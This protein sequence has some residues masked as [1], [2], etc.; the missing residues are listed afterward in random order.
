[1][2]PNMNVT[3]R[4]LLTTFIAF[5]L[6]ISGIAAYIQLGNKAFYDGPVLAHGNY[7][8]SP[9][10]NCPPYDVPVRG[11]I[12]DRNGVKL[13][14]SVQDKEFPC[15]YH[16]QYDPRVATSGLAPLLG[17]YSARYLSEGLEQ[18]YNDQLAGVNSGETASSVFDSLLHKPRYGQD[19]YLTIDINLQVQAAKN[20]SSAVNY[21]ASPGNG[22]CQDPGTSPAGS[23]IAEDPFSGQILAMVSFPSFDPN[24]IDTPGYFQQIQAQAN[25]PFLN[26]ATMGLYTPG[27]TFKTVTLLAALDAGKATLDT[28][29]TKDEAV[30]YQVPQGET[31]RW[32][33]FLAPNPYPRGLQF[34]ISLNQAYW[35]SDNVVFAREAVGMGGDTWLQY[36]RKFGIS[37]PGYDVPPVKFD[38][39]YKQSSAYNDAKDQ[40][41][42]LNNSDLLA[43][44]G[45]GQ[46]H[47]F[48]TP[49]TMTEVSAA[50]AADGNLFEPHAVL[51]RVIH[52][53]QGTTE[54][55]VQNT[56]YGGGALFSPDTAKAVRTAMWGVAS[57]GTGSTVSN[58]NGNAANPTLK[59]SPVKEGGKTGTGQL[60]GEGQRPQT[61]WISLAP[62]DV[63]S[64][65]PA[66]MV[67]TVMK[68]HSGE[69]ACQVFV[70]DDT[71]L[72]AMN[73]HIIPVANKP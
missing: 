27:S 43:E 4:R 22:P 39:P 69:G 41:A 35:F 61:W 32:E 71:Y 55:A 29:Y 72:Y 59:D 73:N 62:D 50:I 53:D 19:L 52:S 7:D 54:Q 11:T 44:S 31:L 36:V 38:G 46:G 8:T 2:N 13:A 66:Q 20:F 23:L 40:Q 26:H 17:Y 28:Q 65:T 34:P 5:F 37:A 58:P 24:K 48:I 42:I 18:T 64:G 12:Y 63:V 14:W 30:N 68:E 33:D 56:L 70:A 67:V 60:G 25:A 1:M 3:I 6:V 51:K 10:R 21:N 45:F 57:V 16:R 9:D 47:L 15:I 49:L